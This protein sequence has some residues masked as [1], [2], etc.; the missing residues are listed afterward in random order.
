MHVKYMLATPHLI[1]VSMFEYFENV[2]NILMKM[3]LGS[4][5]I[6][7]QHWQYINSFYS[8]LCILSHSR[9]VLISHQQFTNSFLNIFTK[10]CKKALTKLQEC[11]LMTKR[12]YFNTQKT[13]GFVNTQNYCLKCFQDEWFAQTVWNLR[14]MGNGYVVMRLTFQQSC[15]G[16]FNGISCLVMLFLWQRCR[17]NCMM[18]Q[19]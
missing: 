17:Q 13:D 6:L 18:A 11:W 10:S 5:K 2:A 8:F 14:R 12:I 1:I 3:L 16:C 15:S 19:E 7:K 4:I 9:K